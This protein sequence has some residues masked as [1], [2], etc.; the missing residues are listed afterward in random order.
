M[1]YVLCMYI[2][3]EDTM[4]STFLQ[5]RIG[6]SCISACQWRSHYN[7][8]R[9]ICSGSQCCPT[10]FYE[11]LDR[12]LGVSVSFTNSHILANVGVSIKNMVTIKLGGK[13]N[14]LHLKF[15]QCGILIRTWRPQW[16]CNDWE[17]L[18]KCNKYE[19][20]WHQDLVNDYDSWVVKTKSSVN[21]MLAG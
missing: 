2:Y 15:R 4:I 18:C 19:I 1:V 5:V 9:I 7:N 8:G 17:F 20:I 6:R 12:I 10:C 16:F 13:L 14:E 11:S 21:Y 3:E